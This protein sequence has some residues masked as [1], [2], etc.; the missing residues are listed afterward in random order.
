MLRSVVRLAMSP[1]FSRI[2][3]Y[4]SVP[5]TIICGAE[6]TKGMPAGLRT[7]RV[8]LRSSSR[9]GPNEVRVSLR[10]GG[11]DGVMLRKEHILWMAAKWVLSMEST[12]T[13]LK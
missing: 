5:L 2:N 7:W 3:P 12:L 1:S 10:K 9:A 4:T 6:M 8:L 13:W 11:V